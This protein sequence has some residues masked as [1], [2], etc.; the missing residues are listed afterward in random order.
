MKY[1]FQ[2]ILLLLI[3]FCFS[4]QKD[5][6]I[7]DMAIGELGLQ[8][9]NIKNEL[10]THATFPNNKAETIL[11]IPEIESEEE[12]CC[13]ELNS[14]I[15][16]VDSNTGKIKNKYF[17]SAETNKWSSD[18]VVLT[19]ITIDS[20]P[21]QVSKNDTAFGIGVEHSGTSKANPYQSLSLSLFIKHK[22][23]LKKVLRNFE[24][25]EY[26]GE[27]DTKCN[28]EFTTNKKKLITTNNL[29]NGFYDIKVNTEITETKNTKDS[30]GNC[31]SEKNRSSTTS[32]LQFNGKVYIKKSL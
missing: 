2:P 1:F 3:A 12:G 17:E 10:I 13:F 30:I 29:T 24:V 8:K 11:V 6:N 32:T 5:P 23:S 25:M 18:A 21:Y 22:N 31:L 9:N 14:Y 20:L 27:W 7:I 15:L 28:G 26:N 16:I 19:Q 4:C